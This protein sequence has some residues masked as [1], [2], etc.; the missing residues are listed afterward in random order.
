MTTKNFVM[1]KQICLV[2]L[3]QTVIV[4]PWHLVPWPNFY[5]HLSV[6]YVQ[7]ID[8]VRVQTGPGRGP[9]G[10]PNWYDFENYDSE[11]DDDDYGHNDDDGYDDA[12]DD[13]YGRDDD[14][15]DG[16]N[17]LGPCS[18]TPVRVNLRQD[19][20]APPDPRGRC[21]ALPWRNVVVW[22]LPRYIS[23]EEIWGNFCTL[24]TFAG[25]VGTYCTPDSLGTLGCVGTLDTLYHFGPPKGK[26]FVTKA[27]KSSFVPD[28]Y[29]TVQVLEKVEI[30]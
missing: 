25:T 15:D 6:L 1:V 30:F 10:E 13:D 11:D 9:G 24:G 19:V 26:M 17:S 22:P 27:R 7:L 3:V 4:G 5:W 29:L 12:E 2:S 20:S 8:C 28:V 23:G 14:N 21:P 18:D 16:T